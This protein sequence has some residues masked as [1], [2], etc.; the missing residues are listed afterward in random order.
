ML[1]AD[2]LAATLP[3][4]LRAYCD[5]RDGLGQVVQLL[6]AAG[7]L[8]PVL[9]DWVGVDDVPTLE[10]LA[11]ELGLHMVVDEV[12]A[13]AAAGDELS[14]VV[15]ADLLNTTRARA[16]DGAEPGGLAH[17]YLG[18]NAEDVRQASASG[19]YNL[20]V[21]DRVVPK[22]WIDHYWFGRLLGYP[23]CCLESF[24]AHGAWNVANP[25]AA[26][27]AS[28]NQANALVNPVH[29][30]RG[31]AYAVHYPC[32]FDCSATTALARSVRDLVLDA[33]PALAAA[34]DE[35]L[36]GPHLLLSG[37]VAFGFPGG[38]LD[39]DTIRYPAVVSAPT[40]RPDD[41]LAELLRR[42]DAVE[43]RGDVVLVRRG[44]LAVG[45]RAVR[46]DR[47]APEHA[48]LVDFRTP[49]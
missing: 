17:V 34:V 30:H 14:D 20:V 2:S 6:A 7:G 4:S 9:D 23:P 16:V 48:C 43:V 44:G 10:H 39:G 29:R 27:T 13:F 12:F 33:S 21:G 37:F 32:R 19:W 31:L 49:G 3:A 41:A 26:A 1:V 25:Y 22:P 45:S 42:G 40:N 38:S 15:G 47:Y 46:A 24:A 18:R 8:K 28:C 11:G 36:T 5:L 35:R